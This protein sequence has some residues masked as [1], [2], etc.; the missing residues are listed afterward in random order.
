MTG[1][2]QSKT[3][4]SGKT[5]LYVYLSYKDLGTGKWKQK[6]VPTG[7]EEKGNKRKAQAMIA[8][9]IEK[10]SYLEDA[11]INLTTLSPEITLLEYLDIWLAQKKIDVETA[12]YESY[13]YRSQGIIRFFKKHHPDIKLRDVTAAMLNQFFTY[14]LQYGKINQK[15]KKPEPLSVRSTRSQRSILYA[16]FN[17]GII[18]GLIKSNPAQAVRVSSKKNKD[19]EEDMLFLTET[20]ISELLTF[21]AGDI[22]YKHLLPIAFMG[23]YLGLRRS[24]ILGLKW[25]A[26]DFEQQ[27]ITIQHTVVR[28]KTVVK[29]DSVK[30]KNSSRT[31]TLFPAAIQCLNNVKREQ[32][33]NKK[34]YQSEYQDT[35]GYVFTWEDGHTYDPNYISSTFKKATKAFGRPEITLHKLRHTCASLLINEGWDPKKLQYWLGHSDI[36]TT[37]NIYAHFNKSR[38]NEAPDDLDKLTQG[39]KFLF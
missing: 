38:M 16:V 5:Y 1:T 9:I 17:Q 3:L 27:R 31:L 7:L 8:S 25:D 39:I 28:A 23:I 13:Q 35:Q 24:E 32:D 26:I 11:P 21:L 10:Y 33:T 18:D 36:S 30:T 14:Q 22:R 6:T 34:F 19:F 4:R 20:E 15:T 12:T 29:K 2:I 37:L